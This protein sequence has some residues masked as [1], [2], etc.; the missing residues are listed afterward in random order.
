MKWILTIDPEPR[1]SHINVNAIM[2]FILVYMCAHVCVRRHNNVA[3]SQRCDLR[4]CLLLLLLLL[5]YTLAAHLHFHHCPQSSKHSNKNNELQTL[6]RRVCVGKDRRTDN[7]PASQTTSQPNNQPAKTSYDKT[8][9][10]LV[11][12]GPDCVFNLYARLRI[13]TLG[14]LIFLTFFTF[15]VVFRFS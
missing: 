2:L 3:D 13:W 15:V 4:S 6:H 5:I 12:P 14:F 11:Q 10:Q 7:Q 1:R 8:D 9:N